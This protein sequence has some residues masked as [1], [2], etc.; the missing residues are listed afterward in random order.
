ME[1][2]GPRV[3]PLFWYRNR[4]YSML[5]YHVG[6][7]AWGAV[8]SLAV[9]RAVACHLASNLK[10]YVT[11]CDGMPLPRGSELILGPNQ[12]S[13]IVGLSW[14]IRKKIRTHLNQERRLVSMSALRI[15]T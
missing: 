6:D 4:T 5:D 11:D 12:R 10:V 14:S 8:S 2:N 9:R 1:L 13:E 15:P 7:S 3:N